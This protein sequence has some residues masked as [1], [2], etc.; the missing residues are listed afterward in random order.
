M[1]DSLNEEMLRSVFNALPSLIFVVDEDVRI[2]EYNA[3][4]SQARGMRFL[5]TG[6][7]NCCTACTR[8][9]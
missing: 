9:T 8:P 5:N 3:S 6:P 4:F 2:K 1:K 7:E